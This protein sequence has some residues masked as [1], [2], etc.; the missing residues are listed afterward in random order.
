MLEGI[1]LGGG[2]HFLSDLKVSFF[3]LNRPIWILIVAVCLTMSVPGTVYDKSS[4]ADSLL[5]GTQTL[6]WSAEEMLDG[7]H[8]RVTSLAMPELLTKASFRKDCKRISA[9]SSL[10][11][12]R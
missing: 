2:E 3:L 8:Q 5:G 9:E 12:L 6:P 4:N 11:S 1:E 10:M 7:Q